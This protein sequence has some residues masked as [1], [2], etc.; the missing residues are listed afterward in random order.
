MLGIREDCRGGV[1]SQSGG[2]G[3]TAGTRANDEDVVKLSHLC[4]MLSF[5]V[6]R[7]VDYYQGRGKEVNDDRSVVC[8]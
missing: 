5:E 3:E 4:R 2:D 6:L 1:F 7:R 8:S